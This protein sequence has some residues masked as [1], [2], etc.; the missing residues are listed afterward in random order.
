MADFPGA[1]IFGLVQEF[2]GQDGSLTFDETIIQT[3]GQGL[4]LKLETRPITINRPDGDV[5]LDDLPVRFFECTSGKVEQ[6][7][8][9]VQHVKIN[10]TADYFQNVVVKECVTSNYSGLPEPFRLRK[11]PRVAYTMQVIILTTLPPDDV[12]AD[13]S[14]TYVHV[15]KHVYMHRRK[16]QPRSA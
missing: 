14:W 9:A 6:L 12:P 5:K 7:C 13:A 10:V 4:K 16:T 3:T 11:E 2:S 8:D 1:D 15:L